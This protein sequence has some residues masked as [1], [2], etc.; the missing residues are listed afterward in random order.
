MNNYF[1]TELLYLDKELT[2]LKTS[3]PRS[4]SL[5]VT[6]SQTLHLDARLEIGTKPYQGDP[7][8]A[9]RVYNYEIVTEENALIIPTLDWYYDD[10]SQAWREPP[11]IYA[12]Y[13]D[14]V[15]VILPNGNPGLRLTVFGTNVGTNNDAERVA[16]GQNVTISFNLTVRCSHEFTIREYS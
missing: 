7:D 2:Y 14:M 1:D 9:V 16:A 11:T 8:V 4:A 10:I 3:M 15:E 5:V 12:R 13:I 6:T